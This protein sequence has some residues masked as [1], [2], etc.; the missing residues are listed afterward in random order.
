MRSKPKSTESR[1]IV[2]VDIAEIDALSDAVQVVIEILFLVLSVAVEKF[3]LKFR[4][5]ILLKN[6]QFTN[7]NLVA[8]CLLAKFTWIAFAEGEKTLD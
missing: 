1:K 8:D 7:Q 3:R 2:A 4:I 6:V 5:L